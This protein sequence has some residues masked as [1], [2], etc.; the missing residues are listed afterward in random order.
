MSN[1]C[2]LKVGFTHFPDPENHD[3]LSPFLFAVMMNR[4]TDDIKQESP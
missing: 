3:T 2:T 1:R 4:L